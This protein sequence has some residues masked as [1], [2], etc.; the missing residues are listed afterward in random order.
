MPQTKEVSLSAFEL[1]MLREAKLLGVGLITLLHFSFLS[2]CAAS[3]NQR[4]RPSSCGDIQNISIPFRL[5]GDPLGC[6]HPDPAYELVCE[7][8][9]T[10][11][12]GKYYVEEIN[13]HNYTIRIIVAGLEKSNC[14][15]LP[16]YSL[17][18]DDLYGY[19]YPVELETVVLMNCARPIFDP[20]YIPIVP[21][22]RTNAT[23]SS[24]QPYAYAL[25][26][27]YM[28]VRD[29]PYSCTI[30]MTVV[31]GN[32]MAVS[33]PS[34]L[35]TD[36]QE[37]LL[38][39]LQLSFLSSRCHECKAKDSWC[40]EIFSNNT[41]QCLDD[42]RNWRFSHAGRLTKL[43]AELVSLKVLLITGFNHAGRED[44]FDQSGFS[45]TTIAIVI[46][47]IGGRFLLGISCLFGYLIYKF[48]RRHLSLDDDIEEFLQNHKNL[49]PIRYS[50]S[51]L[52]K[53]TNN[54]RNKLGQG[55]F[56]S[57]YKGILQSGRIVAV[58]VLVM[59]KANGQDFIN[60]I[61]TIGRIHHVNIVQL[62]GFCVEGSKWALIYDF[63]PNGS[64]DKFIFPK[65]EKHIPLSW[66]R[67]YKIA[68]GVGHG[69]EYLHQGC[70]MQILHFDIKPHNILLDEDFTPKVS[71]FGLAKLYSTNESVVSLTAARGTLG[72]I[73]PELFYKNVGHVSY[74]ADVYSFG[75]LLMEMVGKQRHFS[76][77]H[78]E[79]LSELFFPSWIY[80]RIEQGEDMEMGDVTEDEKKYVWKMVIVALWCVQMKPM[81]RPS[82]SKALDMLEGDVELLQLPP[83]P[84]L[85]SHEIS[86]LDRENKPMGVP[87]SS[88][89][90]SITIS[91]DGR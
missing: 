70:D 71:D 42:E 6:G 28:Q 31:T 36:L 68:L 40:M 83:K 17:T 72:Y 27:D 61:A 29:L 5:K 12:Y 85:Y 53:I 79:D 13:Y 73:A 32:F 22:N 19:E 81:A 35:S 15:S 8:N 82:M 26:A 78:E 7:N 62:V 39:G 60:E 45:G 91:L 59:S 11:L 41:I 63:M 58:K 16:L 23:F 69:I 56:G 37:K 20:Y 25:A 52:K 18:I 55:G 76:R 84:T 77:H 1:M 38:M 80:D 75:M 14:F 30:G 10:I 24:S 51:H 44:A 4:C 86:A 57:V 34:N 33:E 67:L 48:Q 65:G 74:K 89:N 3:E 90:A 88:H 46:A 50:Y 54:F 43:K 2:F 49:Q 47:I 66:D 87:I 64:L 21:C 9:H